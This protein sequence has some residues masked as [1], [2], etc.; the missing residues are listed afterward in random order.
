MK[1]LVFFWRPGCEYCTKMI[2]VID[3][4]ALE[5]PE[6]H[7]TKLNVEEKTPMVNH[8]YKLYDINAVPATIGLI[9]GKLIDGHVGLTSKF[10][11]MSLLG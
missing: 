1:E 7:V 3:E 5:H 6:I 11:A 8:Y 2:G 9:D 10:M 4:I